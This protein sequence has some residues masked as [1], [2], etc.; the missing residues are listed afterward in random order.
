MVCLP[1]KEHWKKKSKAYPFWH[2]CTWEVA[3]HPCLPRTGKSAAFAKDT[4]VIVSECLI[5][6]ICIF[7]FIVE[8]YLATDF[9]AAWCFCLIPANYDNLCS[10]HYYWWAVASLSDAVTKVWSWAVAPA[11]RGGCLSHISHLHI[12]YIIFNKTGRGWAAISTSAVEKQH[13]G[14]GYESLPSR[15]RSNYFSTNRQFI[16]IQF[17][18]ST[19]LAGN[20]WDIWFTVATEIILQ[21]VKL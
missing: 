12:I 10:V 19:V 4:L 6:L 15:K 11:V 14:T 16:Y 3:A 20:N 7:W 5:S 2:V 9:K 18:T 21:N 17:I 13:L 8:L 1:T